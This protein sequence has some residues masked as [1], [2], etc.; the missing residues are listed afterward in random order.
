MRLRNISWN[1]IGSFG[2]AIQSIEFG[3]VGGL[4]MVLGRNG[5]GKSTFL[6]LPKIL[7]YGK[8]KVPWNVNNGVFRR[9]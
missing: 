1:N 7:Y 4:Y 2:N 8:L 6:N 9:F 3:N 5:V